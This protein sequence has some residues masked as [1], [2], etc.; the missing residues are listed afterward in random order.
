M[1]GVGISATANPNLSPPTM[2]HLGD[3]INLPNLPNL[4]TQN[5]TKALSSGTASYWVQPP[6]LDHSKHYFD[7]VRNFRKYSAINMSK[8]WK[9]AV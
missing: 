8:I 9:V 6:L 1:Q 4:L 3:L 5:V 2:P 7:L